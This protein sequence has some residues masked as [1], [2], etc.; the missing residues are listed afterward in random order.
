MPVSSLGS[1]IR[2]DWDVGFSKSAELFMFQ[3]SN[4]AARPCWFQ[5][6]RYD[7]HAICV[8]SCQCTTVVTNIICDLLSEIALTLFGLNFS[9]IGYGWLFC[10]ALLHQ[11]KLKSRIGLNA[12]QAIL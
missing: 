6:S 1:M 9:R 12:Q 4:N 7:A 8:L 11:K 2:N 10:I 5:R 3:S